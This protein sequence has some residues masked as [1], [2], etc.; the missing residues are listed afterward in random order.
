MSRPASAESNVVSL[1]AHPRHQADF[2]VLASD[3]VR[4]AREKLSMDHEDFAAYLASV[5]GWEIMPGYVARWED[6]EGTPPGDVV[7]AAL[8]VAQ[9]VQ[10]AAAVLGHDGSEAAKLYP[11]RGLIGREKWNAIVRGSVEH[12]WLY[13]M[14]EHGYAEDD[15]V[16]GIMKEAAAAGCDIRVL[17]LDPGWA[18]IDGIDGAEGSPAG[19]LAA[20]IAAS[21][22]RFAEMKRQC[23]SRMGL[24]VYCT[25]PSLSVVRG[26]D[27]MLITPYMPPFTGNNSPT[28][29]YTAAAAPKTIGRYAQQFS[30]MW[31]QA[32][33]YA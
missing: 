32:R 30:T 15:E 24:R 33:E 22:A 21:M 13:G 11:S 12:L 29:E 31:N 23:G 4:T 3:R 6:G 1:A 14:A 18:H 25:H 20:R 2:R 8:T 9:D 19:T 26:D 28:F 27:E 5:L 17:L 7:L 16:P 10:A